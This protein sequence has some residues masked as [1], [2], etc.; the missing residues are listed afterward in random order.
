M[1]AGFGFLAVHGEQLRV[2]DRAVDVEQ[3]DRLRLARQQ[4]AAARTQL[5]RREARVGEHRQ[6]T[7]DQRGIRVH[8]ARDDLRRQRHTL[9]L[10]QQREHVNGERETATRIHDKPANV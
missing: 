2:V 6:Q 7:A 5:R 9:L 10:R 3:R 8:A 1:Q 4:R